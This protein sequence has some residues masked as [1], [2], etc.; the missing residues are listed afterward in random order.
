MDKADSTHLLLSPGGKATLLQKSSSCQSCL[1]FSR[2]TERSSS[3]QSAS[4]KVTLFWKSSERFW[5]FCLLVNMRSR[6]FSMPTTASNFAAAATRRWPSPL[7]ISTKAVRPSLARAKTLPKLSGRISPYVRASLSRPPLLFQLLTEMDVSRVSPDRWPSRSGQIQH[8]HFA[9]SQLQV[10]TSWSGLSPKGLKYGAENDAKSC[11]Q[12]CRGACNPPF[13][14]CQVVQ[15]VQRCKKA[16]GH[17]VS[18]IALAI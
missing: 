14:P 16:A 13:L 2:L 1:N 7:P 3:L 15:T 6:Y 8:L 11:R 18:H 10:G 17:G 5:R 12:S 4:N 9:T